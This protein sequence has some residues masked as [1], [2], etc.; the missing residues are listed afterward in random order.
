MRIRTLFFKIFVW[1]WLAMATVNIV[2]LLLTLS[3][4]SENGWRRASV[5]GPMRMYA[6]T[7]AGVYEREGVPSLCDYLT[8]VKKVARLDAF[9]FNERDEEVS[10]KDPS[11]D[12]KNL[13]V[14]RLRG[15]DLEPYFL[16]TAPLVAQNVET[17]D[18][19]RYV[20]VAEIDTH[21]PEGALPRPPFPWLRFFGIRG[22]ET[23]ALFL[24]AMAVFLTAGLVCYGLARYLIAPLASFVQSRID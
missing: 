8:S 18:G 19:H 20:L 15:K 6:H 13:A 14:Q 16:D 9:F 17:A 7:A 4:T 5:A 2:F 1:F 22:A 12:I 23:H 21:R 10:G 24:R 11:L 3:T